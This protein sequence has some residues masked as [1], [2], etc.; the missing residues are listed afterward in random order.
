MLTSI[1]MR[2]PMNTYQ[3]EGTSRREWF[4]LNVI[5]SLIWDFYLF[6]SFSNG[7]FPFGIFSNFF[8]TALF[9]EKL[10][11]HTSLTTLTKQLLFRSIYFFRATAFIKEFRFRK[12]N[13]LV[14]AIFS[15]YLIFRNETSTEQPLCENK[16]F[17]RAVT[18]R[19]SYFFVGVIA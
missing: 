12:S 5:T 3:G 1:H 16:K 18:F 2:F 4:Q 17:F 14:A 7:D 6:L 13:F 8:R 15:E 10:L 11:L 19:N 9:P